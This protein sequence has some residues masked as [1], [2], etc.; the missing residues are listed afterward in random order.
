MDE[1]MRHQPSLRTDATAGIIKLLEEL[2][3]LGHDPNYIA[4]SRTQKFET[5]Q[6][7][8]ART[9]PVEATG[10]GS[11][12]EEEDE[13]EEATSSSN[14]APARGIEA[15]AGAAVPSEKTPV[16]LVDYVL[17]V[18][19]FVDAILSNNS[20]DDHCREFVAQRGLVPLMGILGL[21]NLPVDFPVT[22][23]CQVS[24]SF[25]WQSCRLVVIILLLFCH[26]AVAAVCKS[27]LNLAHEP[28][29]LKHGLDHLQAVLDTL[30]Q[31]HKPLEPP[32]G[33]V[34]L[35][36]LASAP[37]PA[38][39]ITSPSAT[40]LLHA[41]AAAHAYIMMFVHVCRTGQ[42]DI[43]TLS[44]N[45]W[46]S[47]VGLPVLKGLSKL[48][49]SL[50]WESTVLL[51]LCS[52]ETLPQGCQFGRSDLDK[53]L[54]AE[55]KSVTE[56]GPSGSAAGMELGT[57]SVAAALQA[58][59]TEASPPAAMEIDADQLDAKDR[60]RPE[61]LTPAQQHQMK[62]VKPLLSTASRY[63]TNRRGRCSHC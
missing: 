35:R 2:C 29:V 11:S 16:P 34:L 36:E 41:M 23:A 27:I 19:K 14:P 10:G 13:E 46:G 52:D 6:N 32:G 47:L 15:E 18:M 33:S 17:N 61:K 42:S 25:A 12:D 7:T 60:P 38:E 58:L 44:I 22:P 21:P 5:A 56:G 54:P 40:P 45:H 28:Q 49:T 50:V 55:L 63:A 9:G 24:F 4:S 51:A 53:L 37:N 62:M 48:Y 59:S 1:L 3:A 43:R 31:L 20:T 39:A 30:Q 26:Q 8:S 57:N